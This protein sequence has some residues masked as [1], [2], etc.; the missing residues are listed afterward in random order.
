MV[1]F[2]LH[3][4]GI[5]GANA[6]ITK[7]LA[8][9]WKMFKPSLLAIFFLSVFLSKRA[10]LSWFLYCISCLLLLHLYFGTIYLKKDV[11]FLTVT[12][13]VFFFLSNSWSYFS[14][15][16][17][18]NTNLSIWT[19]NWQNIITTSNTCKCRPRELVFRCPPLPPP[20]AWGSIVISGY[21]RNGV[22]LKEGSLNSFPNTAET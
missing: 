10:I 20:H 5:C 7:S 4:Q 19:Y 22:G 21:S 11:L 9:V 1:L 15:L 18:K 14:C 8:A 6:L 16:L 2:C 3:Y 12:F 17:S 13:Y